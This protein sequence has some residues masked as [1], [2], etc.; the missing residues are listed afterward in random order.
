ML[1]RKKLD[2]IVNLVEVS[3]NGDDPMWEAGKPPIATPPWVEP[4][5][6][7]FVRKAVVATRPL[8]TRLTREL[9]EEGPRRDFL[10][11]DANPASVTAGSAPLECCC[12]RVDRIVDGQ[13]GKY[14]GR[15]SSRGQWG[16]F[17]LRGYSCAISAVTTARLWMQ[18]S[19]VSPTR[20]GQPGKDRRTGRGG[21]SQG[22]VL[23]CRDVAIS[24][25]P[26]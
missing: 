12:W 13:L 1:C 10:R 21:N 11:N 16:C 22:S 2:E 26:T 6:S 8:R 17:R 19:I 14:E 3:K 25:M 7:L 24:D 5:Q 9:V 20:L 15:R 23:S 4:H 18:N